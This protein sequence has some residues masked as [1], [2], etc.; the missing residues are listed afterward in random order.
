MLKKNVFIVTTI[1]LLSLAGNAQAA[2]NIQRGAN[3]SYDCIDC[4]GTD[5]KGNFETPPIVG[6]DEAYILQQLKGFC[7]GKKKSLD[8]MMHTYT[9]DRT[10]QEMQDLAAYWASKKN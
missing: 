2:G 9:E 1:L 3:L 6:L 4:H 7:S 5:G 8:G 10:E